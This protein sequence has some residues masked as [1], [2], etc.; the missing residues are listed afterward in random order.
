MVAET[1]QLPPRANAANNYARLEQRMSLL[2]WLQSRL[3]YDSTSHLLADIKEA[4]EGFNSDG[5]S[6]IYVRLESRAR[7]MQE[8]TVEDL[9]R[10]DD[11]IREHL[12]EMNAGRPQPITLRYFQYLAVLCAEIF[13]DR[14]SKSPDALLGSLNAFVGSLNSNRAASEQV[15]LFERD[16]LKKLAFWM[17]TGSGK[18]L[19][20][21]INYRQFLH[22]HCDPL[23]NILLITPN[24]G[25]SQQHLEEMEVSG[26]P[27]VRFDLNENSLFSSA[28]GVVKVTEITKLVMKKKGEGESIPVEALKGN[29]LVFVDEGHKGS[30]GEAWREVRDALG[31]SSFTFEYSA[32]FGQALTAARNDALTAEYG[33]A[34]AFDYSYRHFYNDGYGKDF[35]ILNLLEDTTG[36]QTDNLLLANMLSF[37]EQQLVFD[38][39]GD[40]LSRSYNLE[41]PLW[42]FVGASVNKTDSQNRSDIL[43]VV[44]FLHRF[45]SESGWATEAIARLLE[46]DSG[47]IGYY[48]QDILAGKYNYLHQLGQSAWTIYEDMLV[49][50]LHAPS[51]GGLSLHDIRGHDGEIGL[52]AGGSNDY[53]GLIYIGDTNEFKKLVSEDGSGITV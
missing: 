50:S 44:R 29:N 22:Y 33:K 45:L 18:T 15:D 47:L 42:V 35:H 37:Y 53:F 14:Y 26:V 30:G 8:L 24:E 16:D 27:A 11:N 40:E 52:K 1:S 12:A 36:E 9:Q 43:T 25:L 2:A 49:K 51:G 17:A 38:E 23:D 3:G 41:R 19:L 13:L 10:Y 39:F 21:H 46:G 48:G 31:E 34:I 20:M 6:Y 28:P 5:R 7:K 32:T 4:D